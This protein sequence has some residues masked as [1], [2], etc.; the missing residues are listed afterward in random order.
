MALIIA[1]AY[2]LT[3][4]GIKK[5]KDVVRDDSITNITAKK[6][7]Y[8]TLAAALIVIGL[9]GYQ[10]VNP[11]ASN[12]TVDT[13]ENTSIVTDAVSNKSIAVLP[14]TNMANNA[15]NEPFTLGLHDD[16]LTHLSRISA[17]KVISRTSVMEYK[18]TTKKIKDIANELGVTNILEGGVQRSGNQIRLNVQLI[19]ANTDEHLWAEIYDRELTTK[20]IFNIQTEISQKIAQALKAQL[21]PAET[22]SI[23]TAPTDNL[24]AYDAYLAARQL[25][26]TRESEPLK[27]ALALF[28]QATELD[29]NY[30]LAYVGQATALNLLN[31]YGDLSLAD[32][33]AQGEPLITKALSLDPLLAEAH[34][35]KGSYLKNQGKFAE[36]ESSFKLSLSLNPNYATTYHWYGVMLRNF[37]RRYEE[38][39]ILHRKAAELD[40]LSK[41]IMS[42]VASSLLENGDIQEALQHFQTLLEL[43]PEYP[44]AL[45]SL[46]WANVQLGNYAQA[47]IEQEKAIALDPGNIWTRSKLS[48]FYLNIGDVSAAQVAHEN[49][50]TISPQHD[51]YL[52]HE[53]TMDLFQGNIHTAHQRIAAA[54]ES[55]PDNSD[56]KSG[57]ALAYLL[58]GDCDSALGLW[59]STTP[60]HFTKDYVLSD[61]GPTNEIAIAWCL[62]QT[63]EDQAAEWLLKNVQLF[64]STSANINNEDQDTKIQ[65]LAVQARPK[66]AANAYAK[67]VA[68]KKTHGWFWFDHLPYCAD[69]RKE[70]VFIKA[71]EQLM[72]DLKQQRELLAEFRKNESE[73]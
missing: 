9:F 16:L 14:F 1:W 68:S 31:E 40:P 37:L 71:R 46:A 50:K 19:D 48:Y 21:T 24:Q 51:S 44:V 2:E 61:R 29:P 20:N 8:I 36:A 42:N 27:Q 39:L 7:D 52:F 32:M 67:F 43:H 26:E 25:V 54:L 15:E 12:V 4:E 33:L 47:I 58:N 35:V 23:E 6:L 13:V 55:D 45:T 70:P 60:E 69:I 17:L 53:A 11:S 22:K 64:L 41:V 66:E 59:R 56:F 73:K 63:G 28:Q 5:E 18:N 62:K 34:T 65:L 30:A 3:P 72:L 10:K 57:L 49:T 38:A